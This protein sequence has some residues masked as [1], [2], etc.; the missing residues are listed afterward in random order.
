MWSTDFQQSNQVNVME[1]GQCFQQTVLKQL[2]THTHTHTQNMYM[3][4][5]QKTTTK[6]LQS[7]P[8]TIH[9]N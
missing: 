8:H 7:L 3:H 4:K 9:K 2:Y 5:Q 6:A 1:E